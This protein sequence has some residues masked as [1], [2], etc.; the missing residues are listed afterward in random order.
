MTS[1]SARPTETIVL[2]ICSMPIP[3]NVKQAD[4]R[5]IRTPLIFELTLA[6]AEAL[7]RSGSAGMA[8]S[9]TLPKPRRVYMIL[10]YP[11][12]R[13]ALLRKCEGVQHVNGRHQNVLAPVEHVGLR[14]AR[15]F[16]Q[17]RVPEGTPVRW[18]VG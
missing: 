13:A 17:T 7:P 15:D 1:I 4:C 3:L 10:S 16:T 9:I 8:A 14:R 5:P 2:M 6:A 18:I 12:L 11:S